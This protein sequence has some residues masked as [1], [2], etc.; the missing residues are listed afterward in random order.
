MNFNENRYM[1]ELLYKCAA[2]CDYCAH[3]CLNEDDL[4]KMAEC[5]NLNVICADICRTTA[6]SIARESKYSVNLLEICA[7]ICRECADECSKL[8]PD[9]CKRC[10]DICNNCADY[11]S[12][13]ETAAS[14]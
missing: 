13:K 10:A 6:I 14:H 5:I 7:N 12:R 4:D 2:E 9:F 3:L 1:V 11:C 8:Q